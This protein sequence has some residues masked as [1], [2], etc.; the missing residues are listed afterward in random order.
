MAAGH[1][2]RSRAQQSVRRGAPDM[3]GPSTE[4]PGPYLPSTPNCIS[5]EGVPTSPS[6]RK[7]Q[8]ALAFL[9]SFSA[10]SS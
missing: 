4:A 10:A 1:P 5:G 9:R 6:H 8:S 7:G 3:G 2:R